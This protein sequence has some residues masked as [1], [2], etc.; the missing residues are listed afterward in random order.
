MSR[1]ATIYYCPFCAEE[2]L[3]PQP[4]P[5]SAWQ[6]TACRRAFVVTV[7]PATSTHFDQR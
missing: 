5:A 6:C 2:D 1:A 7:A 3:R 4:E